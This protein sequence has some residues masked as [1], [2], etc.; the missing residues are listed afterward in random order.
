M[1]HGWGCDD[2]QDSAVASSEWH[3]CRGPEA[4]DVVVGGGDDDG[5]V[6]V[7]V[8]AGAAAAVIAAAEA[9]RSCW[10]VKDAPLAPRNRC[11]A[12]TTP[13]H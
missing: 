11:I 8:V 1:G 6:V 10:I 5:V 2:W 12:N 13:F 9:E 3:C 7:V 4:V